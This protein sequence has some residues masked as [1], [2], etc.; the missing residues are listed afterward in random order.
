MACESIP[1][2]L[3]TTIAVVYGGLLNVYLC[4]FVWPLMLRSQI[5]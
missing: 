5:L 4:V 1:Q 2:A 3:E